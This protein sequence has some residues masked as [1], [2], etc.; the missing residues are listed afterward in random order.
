MEHGAW[1]MGQGK[2]EEAE[3]RRSWEAEKKKRE[4]TS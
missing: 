1:G 3:K 2:R 4:K